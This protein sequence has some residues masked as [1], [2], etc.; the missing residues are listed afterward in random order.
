MSVTIDSDE[1]LK[2]GGDVYL[3]VCNR[4]V[5]LLNH[6]GKLT[7]VHISIIALKFALVDA[8]QD[9]EFLKK[10]RQYSTHL[11]E[12]KIAGCLVFRLSRRY[13]IHTTDMNL[14]EYPIFLKL[15]YLVAFA[16][17]LR[18]IGIDYK[19]IESSI[20]N[21]II[22]TMICRHVNQETLG[23]VFDNLRQRF[24]PNAGKPS[25]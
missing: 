21:E 6:P 7:N 25:R 17:G 20:R 15:N 23:I 8:I 3:K 11:S 5:N 16:L 14:I 18:Y 10:R 4:L 13:I 22:F 24:H 19:N 1:F 2:T 12:G 9:I